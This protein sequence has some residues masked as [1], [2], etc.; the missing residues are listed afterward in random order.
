MKNKF[1]TFFKSKRVNIFLLFFSLAFL[2]SLLSKLSNDYTETVQFTINPINIPEDIIITDSIHKLNLTLET[3]G[4][5]YISFYLNR[6]ELKIDISDLEK[7]KNSFLWVERKHLSQIVAQL[8]SKIKIKAISPDTLYF[9][10]DS[11][12]T[13]VVPVVLDKKIDFSPG[14]DLIK[15]LTVQPDSIKIIGSK[16]VL[17]S[18]THI[19][20][21]PLILENV[22]T[23]I[24]KTLDLKLPHNNSIMKFSSA[25]V[26]VNAFVEKFTEGSLELPLQVVNIPEEININYY[27]KTITVLFFISLSDYNKVSAEDFILQC[28]YNDLNENKS[29]LEPKLVKQPNNI[30]NVRLQTKKVEFIIIK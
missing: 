15:E 20:T 1:L 23:S 11:Q 17:D 14:F 5:K 10:Y 24:S 19:K 6:A 2:F 7:Q 26:K 25:S 18:I 16:Q 21:Q 13:K 30:K 12:F 29:F 8:D 3:K 28:D 9:N 4:F 22:K 27:P